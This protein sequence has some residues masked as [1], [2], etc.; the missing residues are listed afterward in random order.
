M[1]VSAD[2]SGNISTSS[3]KSLLT[4]TVPDITPP[5]ISAIA[6]STDTTSA[7]ITWTTNEAATS[8]VNY[9]ATSSYGSSAASS[10]FETSHSVTLTGL[11]PNT[12]YHFRISSGDPSNNYSTSSDLTFTTA[13]NTSF[14]L[15]GGTCITLHDGD[16]FE[17]VSD[18]ITTVDMFNAYLESYFHLRYPTIHLHFRMIARSGGDLND[19]MTNGRYEEQGDPLDPDVVAVLMSNNGGYS[20]NQYISQVT[21][22]VNDYIIGMSSSTPLLF[23]PVPFNNASGGSDLEQYAGKV[24]TFATTTGY[25]YADI[26]NHLHPIWATNLASSSPVDI[27]DGGDDVHMGPPAHLSIAYAMLAELDADSEVS[28]TTID[29]STGSLV[30]QSQTTI[31]DIATTSNGIDFTRLDQALPMGYDERSLP[32]FEIMPQIYDLNKYMLTIKNLASGYYEVYVDGRPS[33]TVSST[34]LAAGWNMAKMSH[35]PIF[36]QLEEV[37]GR[38]RDKEGQDRITRD[39]LTPSSGMQA[40]LS[41]AAGCYITQGLRGGALKTCLATPI[42]DLGDLDDLIYAAAQPV[43]RDFS[44]QKITGSPDMTPPVLSNPLPS[45]PLSQGSTSTVLGIT[46]DENAT[47]RYG[48]VAQVPYSLMT[49]TFSTTGGTTHTQTISGLLDGVTY[50]YYVRCADTLENNTLSDYEVSF[51]VDAEPDPILYYAFDEGSGSSAADSSGNGHTGTLIGSPTWV[52]GEI[53]TGALSFNGSQAVSAGSVSD[54]GGV[55]ALTVSAWVKGTGTFSGSNGYTIASK[56][57]SGQGSWSMAYSGPSRLYSCFVVNNSGA[58]AVALGPTIALNDA[59]WHLVTC[60]YNGTNITQYTDGATS[61]DASDSPALTG[62][63]QDRTYPVC[64]GG[65]SNGTSCITTGGGL[66][67]GRIDDVKIWKRALSASEVLNMYTPDVT[68][69][70]ISSIATSTADTTA[71]ITWHTNEN[72]TSSVNYGLTSSYGSASSS[73][74]L[75]TD[76]SIMLS[77]LTA[78]TVYHFRIGSADEFGNI[79][80]SSDQTFTTAAAVDNSPSVTTSAATSVSS[81]TMALNGSITS[82]HGFNATQSGFAYGTSASL[83]SV[84]AT[85]TLGAQ[86]GTASF[87]SSLTGLTPNTLYYFRAYASSTQGIG[88]G[89]I[90]S[91]T[92]LAL[93]RPTVTTEAASSVT[94]TSATGN[95]TIVSTGNINPGFRG[96]VYGITSRYGATTTSTGDFSAGSFTGSLTSLTCGTTYHYAAYASSTQGLG[97]GSD[98]TFTPACLSSVSSISASAVSSTTETIAWTS[99][100]LAS[101]KVD[102]GINSSYGTTTPESDISPRVTSHSVTLAPLLPCTFYHYRVRSK[103]AAATQV[104]GS[105]GT[106]T[107]SGCTASTAVST[108]TALDITGSGGTLNARDASNFGL[109]LTVPASFSSTTSSA[110]FQAKKLNVSTFFGTVSGPSSLSLV[111]AYLYNL[112][113]LSDAT[114]SL[115][116]FDHPLTVSIAYTDGDV[117]NFDVATLAIQRYDGSSWTLLNNCAVDTTAKTVTCDTDGFS[118]FALFGVYTPPPSNNSGSSGSSSS[119]GGG[120]GGG[121]FI[122]WFTQLFKPATVILGG[123][124]TPA[125]QPKIV[126]PLSLSL[127]F[128]RNLNPGQSGNDVKQLQIFLNIHGFTVAKTGPG[129]KGNETKLYGPATEAA[130]KRFQAAYAKE[131]L[132]PNGFTKPTGIFGIASRKQAV[133]ISMGQQ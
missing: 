119:S 80:T 127:V 115:H 99:D 64:I 4:A 35:G 53:G 24:N 5:V 8:T 102:F 11:A 112:E 6:S 97:Y 27:Q 75:A 83:A 15:C 114:T 94:D 7:H 106:F 107:T 22:F 2:A 84:I 3:E 17:I 37:V 63:I 105:D 16:V 41:N 92:T 46:T 100:V 133:K 54:A 104:L 126:P 73:D 67:E 62:I 95:G 10:T 76:H 9:G 125:L 103:D 59:N 109:A 26:W 51:S 117:A 20:A 38:T 82:T 44:L 120:G 93:S 90:Q 96:F 33:A 101:S 39:P 23:T 36:E 121:G 32:I 47:C 108:T 123:T 45:S 1:V 50:T 113:A 124:T 88:Y 118:D 28:S 34:E 25:A 43:A 40:Y 13:S 65:V 77:G 89:S 61:T 86:T 74:S 12:V 30:S 56:Y 79:S 69:P 48:T 57:T 81:S 116:Y 72:A 98:T 14:V 42:Q 70:V 110:S 31:S 29:A 49:N 131:I 87:Q 78:S 60:V 91:T 58:S 85:T 129:S 128:T 66:W 55:G 68:A 71:T 18:S 122:D 130:V 111:G 132:Y 21:D 19:F 52:S